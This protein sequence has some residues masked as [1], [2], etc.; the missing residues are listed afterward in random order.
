MYHARPKRVY[1]RVFWERSRWAYWAGVCGVLLLVGA[2]YAQTLSFKFV[3][4]DDQVIYGRADYQSPSRWLEAVRQPLDFSPNYFRPLALSTLLVQIWV[5]KEDPAPFHAANVLIH[6]LNTALVMALACRLGR[7]S[8]GALLAGALYGI[9]PALIESVAF[10]SSRYDLTMTLFLLLALWLEGRLQG[11][12]RVVGVSLAFLSALL[13]KEMALMF[14]LVLMAWQLAQHAER[15][16]RERFDA[17]WRRE[18]LLYAVLGATLGVYCALRYAALGY[19]FTAPMG[20][21]QVDAGTPLQHLLLIGRTLTTLAVVTVFPFF[22]IT[23]AHHSELPIPL[24]DGW[25][26]AQLG[27]AVLI[28]LWVAYLAWRRPSGGWLLVAG[29]VSL[30]PVLNLRPLEFAFGLFTAERFLTFPLALFLLGGGQLLRLWTPFPLRASNSPRPQAPAATMALTIAVVALW[31]VGLLGATV[32]NLPN[33][34]DAEH[35][36]RWVTTASPQSPIGFSNLSDLYNK[37]G[38]YTKGLE[39]AEKA[40]Q[41]APHSGMGYVNKGVALLRLGSPNEALMLFRQATEVD[42]ANVIA[43]NNLAAMLSEQGSHDEAERIIKQHVLGKPPRF[44]GRQAL[45]LIYARRARLDLAEA[46]FRKAVA[47]MPNPTGSVALEGLQ[48]LRPAS[49]WIAAAH[50]WMNRGE[51]ALAEVHLQVAAQR[52]P[53]KIAYG[54]ALSRLRILQKRPAEAKRLLTEI[55]ANGYSDPSLVGLLNEAEQMLRK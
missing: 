54:I 48:Q 35:F 29:L 5:W 42:P 51:L 17:L 22:S 21:V 2:L 43:W 14:P 31:G 23:P 47:L 45:G 24:R 28:L 33:W 36:W 44:L 30:V 7:A 41:V 18:R 9:H 53:D 3:W 6:L 26:W 1:Y 10:V 20:E 52:D 37:M 46:E 39:Y 4:D 27:I 25:A 38:Q 13:C 34:R 40:I 32:Y 16:L 55:Q 12:A 15:S 11:T 50:Y 49:K 19:L 8:G